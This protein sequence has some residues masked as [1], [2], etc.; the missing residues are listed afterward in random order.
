MITF[1]RLSKTFIHSCHIIQAL[2]NFHSFWSH[3]TSSPKL[4]FFLVTFY[5]LSHFTGFQKLPFILI[6]FYRLSKTFI[7]SDHILQVIQS[8]HSFILVTFYRLFKTFIY[9]LQTLHTFLLI[10]AVRL[11]VLCNWLKSWLIFLFSIHLS[12]L[13]SQFRLLPQNFALRHSQSVDVPLTSAANRP[14]YT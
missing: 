13:L 11:T 3:N 7:H 6:T 9:S 14:V 5:R 1:Y 8:F 4:S 10:S 12:F 2:Q